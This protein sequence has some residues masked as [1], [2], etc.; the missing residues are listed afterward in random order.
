MGQFDL[1]GIPA[2]KTA[3]HAADRGESRHRRSNSM[4]QRLGQGQGDQQGAVDPHPGDQRPLEDDIQRNGAGSRATWGQGPRSC[5]AAES[6]P[7]SGRRGRPHDRE[8]A[9]MST[10]TRSKGRRQGGDQASSNGESSSLKASLPRRSPPGPQR[11]PPTVDEAGRGAMYKAQ[12]GEE[13]GQGE[14]EAGAKAD[15]R[16]RRRRARGGRSERPARTPSVA[17]R[18]GSRKARTLRAAAVV[19]PGGRGPRAANDPGR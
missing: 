8:G 14:G 9:C 3:R 19:F 7:Q 10:A 4:R 5:K 16:H 18:G 11:T 12:T 1:V 17:R 13:R 15:D 2:E 6:S